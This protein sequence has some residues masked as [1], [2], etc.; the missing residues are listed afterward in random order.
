MSIWTPPKFGN[1][2]FGPELTRGLVGYWPLDGNEPLLGKTYDRSGYG[3]HGTLVADTHSV[4]SERGR[5]MSFDGTGDYVDVGNVAEL[6]LINEGTISAW[7]KTGISGWEAIVSKG[8]WGV[9]RNGYVLELISG[10]IYLALDNATAHS[11]YAS[12]V[13]G[14]NDNKWHN[15]VVNWNG[16]TVSFYSDSAFLS[17]SVQTLIPTGGVYNF[18]IGY[19]GYYFN[20]S[21]DEVMIFNRALS[22]QEVQQ[23]YRYGLHKHRD[24][25]ELWNPAAPTSGAQVIMMSTM[26][27]LIIFLCVMG[28]KRKHSK[29]TK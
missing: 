15:I 27:P 6:D 14:L 28:I 11:D 19:E 25:I 2:P 16:T 20:G 22:A 5:V 12:G 23:L 21:I 4:I 18:K 29:V 9:I 10:Q 17:N 7:V 26:G 3:N 13:S 8:S 1:A 24:P